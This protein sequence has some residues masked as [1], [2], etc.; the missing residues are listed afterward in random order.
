MN[1]S[2]S[3]RIKVIATVLIFAAITLQLWQLL[4]PLPAILIPLAKITLIVLIIHAIEGIIAAA[5]ILKYKLNPAEKAPNEASV[6][7]VD[8]L[9]T[10]TLPAVIKAGLYVFFVGTIGLK[11][12]LEGTK[13]EPV[14]N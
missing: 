12:V 11:E 8:H 3:S 14:E 7:L 1:K 5:L 9:P 2:T 10:E 13:L 4:T 6:L